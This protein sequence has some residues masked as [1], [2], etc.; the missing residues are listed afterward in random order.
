VV[1]ERRTVSRYVTGVIILEE[2]ERINILDKTSLI[3][4]PRLL[5]RPGY[6]LTVSIGMLLP[7]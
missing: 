2:N 7:K 5:R 4:L 3:A 1:G 6:N